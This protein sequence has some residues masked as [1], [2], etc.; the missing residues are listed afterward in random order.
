M[1]GKDAIMNTEEKKKTAK[2]IAEASRRKFEQISDYIFKHPECGGNEYQSAEYLVEL[3]R[4]EGFK[5]TYPFGSESTAFRAEKENGAG[6]TICFLA[7]YDALPGYGD[8]GGPGHACGH[9]WIAASSAGA[10][11]TLSEMIDE[12]LG[13]IVLIGTPAEETYNGKVN[14]IKDGCFDDIDIVIE[15][16]LEME[17]EITMTS[18]A[19]DAVEFDFKGKA[20]HASQYPHEGINAL[21]AV[22]LTYA[23]VNSL[24][25]HVL[26][27]VR[28]HGIISEGGKAPNIIPDKAVCQFYVRGKDRAY[29]NTVTEKVIDCAKGAALMTGAELTHRMMEAPV[30][31]IVTIPILVNLAE[32]NLRN[33]EFVQ[34]H[35]TKDI[36]PGSTDI[37]NVSNM[38]PTLYMEIGLDADQPFS[39]HTQTAMEYANSKYAYK[40]LNQIIKSM[41]GIAIDLF[42]KPELV[43]KAKFELALRINT[44]KA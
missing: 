42:D 12:V 10:V 40:K 28:I 16:H 21:D 22:L 2:K 20:V 43:E 13:K 8:D 25:Q 27:D 23:G 30:D 9:N 11:I 17:T 39:V 31:N 19:M 32:E 36:M 37:G 14:M 1:N 34:V 7:E 4:K 33:N 41:C 3:M 29:L 44:H 26:P 15:S 6:P 38:L 35:R 24:R 5:V 18:L